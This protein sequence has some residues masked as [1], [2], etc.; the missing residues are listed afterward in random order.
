V[1]SHERV[2]GILKSNQNKNLIDSKLPR[3]DCPPP[4]Y[5]EMPEYDKGW[6]AIAKAVVDNESRYSKIIKAILKHQPIPIDKDF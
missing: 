1:I 3:F 2:T 6:I 5:E 4:N